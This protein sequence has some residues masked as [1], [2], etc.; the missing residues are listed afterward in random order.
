MELVS[1]IISQLSFGDQWL[2]IVY[3]YL[4]YYFK[5]SR[6][7][8]FLV[9]IMKNQITG[10]KLPSKRDILRVLFYNMRVVNLSLQESALLVI[11]ECLIYWKK[12]RIPTH[13]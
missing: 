1:V 5:M 11:D 12:A 2:L 7:Q 8:V 10:G 9:G 4:K 3:S 13:H 6:K